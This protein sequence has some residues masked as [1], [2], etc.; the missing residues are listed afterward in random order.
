VLAVEARIVADRLVLRK[1]RASAIPSKFGTAV[2]CRV[3]H[4]GQIYW[5]EGEVQCHVPLAL[6]GFGEGESCSCKT[7]TA[8]FN[9]LQEEPSWEAVEFE[10]GSI[11][12]PFEGK[13]DTDIEAM[14]L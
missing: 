10:K 3:P 12:R 7:W 14:T 5:Q 4:K 8:H 13:A 2:P 11:G 6:A 1:R 9:A